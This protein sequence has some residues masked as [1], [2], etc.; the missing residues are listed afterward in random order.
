MTI[1]AEVGGWAGSGEE[2][3]FKV[4]SPGFN[5][6]YPALINA[7]LITPDAFSVMDPIWKSGW[8]GP[9]VVTAYLLRDVYVAGDGIVFDPA[10]QP[11]L[12]SLWPSSPE[13]VAS[14]RAAI[15]QAIAKCALPR[16]DLR[17]VLCRKPGNQNYGH[18][19]IE[20]FPKAV[21][22]RQELG[23]D[24]AVVV[25]SG[26]PAL[27]PVIDRSPALIGCPRACV[28]RAGDEPH[29]HR[30]LVVVVGMTRH[31]RYMSPLAPGAVS[32]MA[33]GVPAGPDHG[34]KIYVCRIE[35]SRRQIINQD[36]LRPILESRGF[37]I[38]TP[39]RLSLDE[40]C[41]SFR[42]ARIVVGAVGAEL[43]NIVFCR[44]GTS[45]LALVPQGMPDTFFWFIAQHRRLRYAELRSPTPGRLTGRSWNKDFSVKASDLEAALDRIE[46]AAIA[47]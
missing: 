22:A 10:L 42:A 13:A 37:T 7:E 11:F 34:A 46:G 18:W 1:S 19:L 4:A 36:E 20:M 32:Q 33:A 26:A 45:V 17:A 14:A 2:I 3:L 35:G 39:G 43:A 44:A 40:Q 6:L 31:G 21:I 16:H 12:P 9:R 25:H 15:E 47:S 29:H 5:T 41:R 24:L 8:V 27:R 28:I 38:V 23:P 30:E